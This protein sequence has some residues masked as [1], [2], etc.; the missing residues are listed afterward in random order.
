MSNAVTYRERL[1][2]RWPV[3]VAV[4]CAVGMLAFA[5]GV[6]LGAVLGWTILSGGLLIG[7]LAGLVASPVITVSSDGLRAGRAM[8][9]INAIGDTAVLDHAGLEA[10]RMPGAPV[11]E[12]V[13]GSRG[14]VRVVI[15]DPA[16]PHRAWLLS[17]GRPEELAQALHQHASA[18]IV[19][20]I[21]A[22]GP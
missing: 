6:A 19:G 7:L 8:L 3:L 20:R 12:V 18:R 1:L 14:G 10:A 9:P 17:S 16:D 2:P 5:Y 11:Y 4:V 21:H 13:R 22:D 15:S